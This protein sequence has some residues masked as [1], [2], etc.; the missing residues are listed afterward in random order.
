LKTHAEGEIENAF[1]LYHIVNTG[2]EKHQ[3]T[4]AKEYLSGA[5]QRCSTVA[6]KKIDPVQHAS[7]PKSLIDLMLDAGSSQPE[8]TEFLDLLKEKVPACENHVFLGPIKRPSRILCK[9][10]LKM[11]SRGMEER[12]LPYATDA[13]DVIRAMVV[14]DSFSMAHAIGCSIVALEEE[15]QLICTKHK[16]RFTKPTEGGW[17]DESFNVVAGS[18][19]GHNQEVQVA[20][21]QMVVAR[22]KMGGHDAF[23]GVRDTL[24]ILSI[25]NV[26]LEKPK[27]VEDLASEVGRMQEALNAAELERAKME[28][29]ASFLKTKNLEDA[30]RTAFKLRT[31]QERI[32]S[33]ERQLKGFENLPAMEKQKYA[34]E[35]SAF[36]K[37]TSQAAYTANREMQLI[38]EKKDARIEAQ[39]QRIA[40][41]ESEQRAAMSLRASPKASKVTHASSPVRP[42]QYNAPAADQ[43]EHFKALMSPAKRGV[44]T[45]KRT[46]E[47]TMTFDSKEN[48]ASCVKGD[49]VQVVQEFH[50]GY[51]IDGNL[52]LLHKDAFKKDTR[53][54]ASK[55]KAITIKCLHGSSRKF[56]VGDTVCATVH[57]FD[58]QQGKWIVKA[59]EEGVVIGP[60]SD[61]ML[62][63]PS[64]FLNV[65]WK[66]GALFD[67]EHFKLLLSTELSLLP[68]PA[69]FKK[70]S[71]IC[72]LVDIDVPRQG[73]I[74]SGDVG[75]V[76]SAMHP[77]DPAYG[78]QKLFCS[79]DNF[80]C[81]ALVAGEQIEYFG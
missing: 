70:L 71:S 78:E 3:P 81:F 45:I 80:P 54:M 64:T 33:L 29:T 67:C 27:L 40:A 11:L 68:M 65:K 48:L 8:F 55:A 25:L 72:S 5:K 69:G 73:K 51:K 61:R 62:Y 22:E 46:V 38:V 20:V 28:A 21:E 9:L 52:K 66:G 37:E 63:K 49:Q 15:Q 39:D 47:Q 6:A 76:V 75:T 30:E 23:E 57:M 35:L 42:S 26:K 58:N 16:D 41:L 74:K 59:N 4:Q 79:F 34:S 24:A 2:M 13:R 18:V 36:K 17:R 1:R 56:E 14:A 50:D 44:P 32:A 60:C 77:D 12:L 53:S 19:A 43:P 7:I 10:V 31:A